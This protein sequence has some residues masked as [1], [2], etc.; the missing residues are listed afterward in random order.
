MHSL[1]KAW[2]SPEI[3]DQILSLG[4]EALPAEACG[5]I[6]PDLQVVELPNCHPTSK[7]DAFVIDAEDLVDAIAA[8]IERSGVDPNS[9]S[10]EHF[11]VWHTHPSGHV[12]PSKGDME[13]RIEGFQYLVVTL[14]DGPAT[15]F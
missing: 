5:I 15:V 12:G 14:P 3:V 1:N 10:R 6:T 2:P 7:E 4:M 13:H 9:L 8:Y 11:M